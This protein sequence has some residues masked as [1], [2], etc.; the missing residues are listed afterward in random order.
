MTN[1]RKQFSRGVCFFLMLAML[2]TSYAFIG[3]LSVSAVVESVGGS[4]SLVR[5]SLDE[6]KSVLTGL[7]YSEYLESHSQVPDAD[8]EI[9]IDLENY[10]TEIV[11]EDGD[12]T[13]MTT[14]TVQS[15]SG[16]DYGT[17]GNVLLVGDDGKITWN[18]KVDKT[19]MY[20]VVIEYYTG[21]FDVKDGEGNIVSESK[22]ASIEIE[23]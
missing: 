23:P 10:L 7:V 13:K 18:I 3:G 12:A 19:A 11:D 6:I 8:D 9:I 4:D 21:D 1:T 14:A 20:S 16:S 17:D 15:A 22:S 5:T 2:F